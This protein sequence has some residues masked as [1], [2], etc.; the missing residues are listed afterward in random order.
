MIGVNP[1]IPTEQLWELGMPIVNLFSRWDSGWYAQI[2]LRGYPS[3]INPL[4]HHWTWFPLF[5]V[6]MRV[7]GQPFFG[8]LNSI[9]AV[10]LAGFLISNILFFVNLILF[11]KLS[12]LVLGNRKLGFYSS[13][14]FAFWPGSLFYSCVY[15]ESLFMTLTLVAFYFLEK[16]KIIKLTLFGFLSGLTRSNGFLSFI[17]FL[18]DGFKERSLKIIFQAFLVFTPYLLFNLYGYLSTGL[19]PIREIVSRQYWGTPSFFLIQLADIEIE[20]AILFSIEYCLVILPFFFIFLS[21]DLALTIFTL[22]WKGTSKDAKYYGYSLAN[23]II[24]LFY[25]IVANVHRYAIVILPI[26]WIYAKIFNAKPNVG[27]FLLNLMIILLFVGTML[28]ST[29][30]W[31]W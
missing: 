5:P 31:Y 12:E 26:Y 9:Q 20:Y 29:L 11:Y 10:I 16:G 14:F 6:S 28:F 3:I 4:S 1:K 19:F 18:Y 22:N 25:S 7:L 17:P 24:L 21:K 8:L 30:R 23:L 15:S 2:A 27:M 13:L